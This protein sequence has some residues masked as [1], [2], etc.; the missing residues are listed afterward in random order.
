MRLYRRPDH[1]ELAAGNTATLPRNGTYWVELAVRNERKAVVVVGRAFDENFKLLSWVRYTDWIKEG[2][3]AIATPGAAG[4]VGKVVLREF[5]VDPWS[6]RFVSDRENALIWDLAKLPAG[7]HYVRAI[8]SDAAG[9]RAETCVT[10]L[11]LQRVTVTTQTTPDI[12]IPALDV[13]KE[14]EKE[15]EREEKP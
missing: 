4:V 13:L 9:T 8:V 3:Q 2:N 5:Y 14:R 1:Q 12:S 6:A 11:L 7:R 10:P 15:K